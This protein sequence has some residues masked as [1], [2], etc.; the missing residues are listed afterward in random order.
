MDGWYKSRNVYVKFW[1]VWRCMGW[2]RQLNEFFIIQLVSSFWNPSNAII[3]INNSSSRFPYELFQLTDS[4]NPIQFHSSIIIPSISNS[5][6]CLIYF[7][8]DFNETNYKPQITLTLTSFPWMCKL[9]LTL[10]LKSQLMLMCKCQINVVFYR[11]FDC[12]AI[13]DMRI[14][15]LTTISTGQRNKKKKNK[16]K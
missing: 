13:E 11:P 14:N 12:A 10:K 2:K 9:N 15:V 7:N 16:S 4:Q 3:L 1:G 8:N 6:K 5:N